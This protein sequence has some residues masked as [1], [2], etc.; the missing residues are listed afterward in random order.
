VVTAQACFLGS[1]NHSGKR[2]VGGAPTGRVLTA[3][4]LAQPTSCDAFFRAFRRKGF[5]SSMYSY[6]YSAYIINLIKILIIIIYIAHLI[7]D[8][9][10]T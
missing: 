3:R 4:T 8:T 10:L 6:E 7:L 9:I 1:S 2:R 5:R